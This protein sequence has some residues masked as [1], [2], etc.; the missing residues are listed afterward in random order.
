MRSFL[1]VFF[2]RY[3][4]QDQCAISLYYFHWKPCETDIFHLVLTKLIPYSEYGASACDI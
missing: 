4:I 1:D 3:V 2:L